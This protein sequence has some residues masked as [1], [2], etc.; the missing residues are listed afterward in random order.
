M[1]VAS[2]GLL[3][4]V[5]ACPTPCGAQVGAVS[6]VGYISAVSPLAEI[7]GPDPAN[8]ALRAFVHRLRELGYA[9]GRNLRLEM[10]SLAGDSSRLE[11]TTAEL[12]MRGVDVLVL[13]TSAFVPRVRK[14]MASVPIVM[15]VG[16]NVLETGL[17]ESLARPGGNLTGLSVDVDTE[18]EAKRLELLLEVAPAARRVAYVGMK[19]DFDGIYGQRV[20]ATARR[21]GVTLIHAPSTA[22]GVAGA[23]AAVATQR[24]DGIIVAHGAVAYGHRREIGTLAA[25]S[26]VPSSCAHSETVEHGCLMSYGASLI[27]VLRRTAD[28][29]DRILKGAKAGDLPIEQPTAFELTI[30][31]KTARATGVEIPQ[32]L[33]VRADRVFE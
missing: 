4:L 9:E 17:V 14:V 22:A 1:N 2:A 3:V 27:H 31:T 10:R 23:F 5:L 18:V 29:V 15:L 26:G 7:T 19:E 28:Y 24:P 30:N 8:P 13:P 6:R 20:Q 21:L 11:Q 33:L 16:S 25:A 32:S 12:V